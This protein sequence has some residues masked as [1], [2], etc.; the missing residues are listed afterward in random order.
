MEFEPSK[1][2]K[3][4]VSRGLRPWRIVPGD[5]WGIEGNRGVRHPMANIVTAR[6]RR[7]LLGAALAS[8]IATLALTVPAAAGGSTTR[9]V[10]DD[11]PGCGPSPYATVQAAIDASSRRR[12]H[13]GLPRRVRRC[14]RSTCPT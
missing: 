10:D 6:S 9:Y 13:P 3:L 1:R 7:A 2:G 14:S 12:H 4:A 8:L 5:N 11:D